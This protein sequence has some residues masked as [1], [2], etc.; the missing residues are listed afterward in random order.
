MKSIL[1]ISNFLFANGHG[2]KTVCEEL[3]ERLVV[4][5]T[6]VIT[7]SRKAARLPRLFDM[8][9]TVWSRRHD[10]QIA[11]VA[12]FSGPAFIWAEA[13]CGLLRRL[14]KPYVL[15]L[16]GGNLPVFAQANADRVRRLLESAQ[17][18]L[19]PSGYLQ[20]SMSM[21]RTD[22][23]L[24]ENALDLHRYSF[25]LRRCAKPSLI[26]LRS[27][28]EIYNPTLAPRVLKLIADQFPEAHLTMV[29]PDKK[30]GS[31]EKTK[32]LA[33]DLCV[34]KQVTFVGGI[35]KD[36]VPNWL[37]RADIFLNTSTIDNTPVSV[38][39]ALACGLCVISTEVGGIPFLLKKEHDALLVPVGD[40]DAMSSAVCRIL[41]EPGL[42]EKL[43]GNAR[44]K[45]EELDWSVIL[46]KWKKVLRLSTDESAVPSCAA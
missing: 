32:K 7:T 46:P 39:E 40:A 44:S 23:R 17:S 25:R 6:N 9:R 1:L 20:E 45:A 42:A 16:H 29:G 11:H 10:Y 34:E 15:T 41:D 22:V 5:G 3:A 36:E 24:M 38:L 37:A 30:D 13:C 8:L 19:S 12:V 21:Y 26:W 43:S 35:R 14:N 4:E 33:R 31:L 18:V 2:S 28:H 27:F